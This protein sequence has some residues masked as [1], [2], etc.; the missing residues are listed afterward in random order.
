MTINT[1]FSD[2]VTMAFKFEEVWNPN[3]ADKATTDYDELKN[4]MVEQVPP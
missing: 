1:L 4:K 2:A 3:Y